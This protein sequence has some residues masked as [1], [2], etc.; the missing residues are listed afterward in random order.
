MEN[1]NDIGNTIKNKL[2]QLDKTPSNNLWNKIENDLDKKNN[3]KPYLYYLLFFL[4]GGFLSFLLSNSVEKESENYKKEKL[5]KDIKLVS[6]SLDLKSKSIIT[7]SKKN[8]INSN[9]YLIYEECKTYKITKKTLVKPINNVRNNTDNQTKNKSNLMTNKKIKE[10][11]K[12]KSITTSLN[13]IKSKTN[14]E[15]KKPQKN[16]KKDNDSNSSFL[17]NQEGVPSTTNSIDTIKKDSIVEL[18]IENKKTKSKKE[19]KV[20]ETEKNPE[21]SKTLISVF[22]GPTFFNTLTKGSSINKSLIE[23]KKTTH[24]ENSFGAYYSKAFKQ[25]GYRAGIAKTNLSYNSI[26]PYIN[27]S[28][29]LD[30]SNINPTN[31]IDLTKINNL[32]SNNNN[33]ILRQNISYL[34]FPLEVYKTIYGIE[35]KFKI[36]LLV[37]ITP[38]F[39]LSNSLFLYD[40]KNEN[41]FKLGKASNINSFNVS[42]QI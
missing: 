26:V 7:T 16:I 37:G 24:I 8:I 15:D 31:E 12:T 2:S 13:E 27:N 42:R 4:L 23:T 5:K 9:E 25:N 38:E 21:K 3:N 20:E 6:D 35:K 22:Y 40:S 29:S 41:E 14:V 18:V 11:K 34:Q 28:F 10:N 33:I 17:K 19:K 30:F 32:Y 1:N 36:N 39:L